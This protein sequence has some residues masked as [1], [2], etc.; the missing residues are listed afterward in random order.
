[1]KRASVALFLVSFLLPGCS[2][3]TVNH[4]FD[5]DANFAAYRTYVWADQRPSS[6]DAG[7]GAND[8]IAQRI[9]RAVDAE[10][11]KEGLTRVENNPDLLVAFHT[12][13]K[14]KINVTDW[15]YTYGD[16]YWGWGG[17]QID[18]YQYQQGTLVVDLI[19]R[20]SKELVWRG[21]AQ[22]TVDENPSPQKI[23][24]TIQDAVKKMFQRYPPK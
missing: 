8:L 15:G 18:V 24:R 22:K 14:D 1:V 11:Q 10:L 9:R 7:A 2:S 3:L 16:Y 19:E 21:W 6:S 12:G 4:D 17:R 20:S 13:V 5:P 23:D